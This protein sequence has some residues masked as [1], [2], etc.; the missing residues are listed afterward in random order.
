M[1]FTLNWYLFFHHS[2]MISTG[3]R[4]ENSCWTGPRS[5]LAL[6]A[7]CAAEIL[8]GADMCPSPE[9]I[10][11][12]GL[13]ELIPTL[14]LAVR[15]SRLILAERSRCATASGS[16]LASKYLDS[17]CPGSRCFPSRL[18]LLSFP[19]ERAKLL[20]DAHKYSLDG[21]IGMLLLTHLVK[22]PVLPQAVTL[23]PHNLGENPAGG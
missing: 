6:P 14:D 9:T 5:R 17:G 7:P 1:L 3:E 16:Y 13:L 18:L 4:R 12:S 8:S 2:T 22:C 20:K 19:Y 23:V 21:V 10:C 15:S 11:H